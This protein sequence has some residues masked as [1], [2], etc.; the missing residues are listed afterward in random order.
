MKILLTGSSGRVGRAIFGAL[1]ARHEV[2]GVDR[3]PFNTTRY[4]ADITDVRTLRTALVGVDAVIHCAAL[5]APHVG[6][7]SDTEF[8][9]I[10]VEGTRTLAMLARDAGVSRFVFTSTTALYGHA[11]VPG[12][13]TWIDERTVPQ[14]RTVYHRSKLAAEHWL[15]EAASPGFQV[16]VIRMSR[17]FPET[18]QRM[19]LYRLHRGIDVRD[20]A[21]AHAAALRNTGPMFQRYIASGAT[22]FGPED[23]ERLVTE[24]RAVLARRCPQWLAEYDRRGWALPVIDRIHD[25]TAASIGLGWRSQRGPEAV[26]AQLDEHSI[27][28]LPH[29]M[30][31]ADCTVG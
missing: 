28:V 25:A 4:V 10:N 23:C 3:S 5:H 20:V 2:V 16:R 9:R 15:E 24:P 27:E 14:P 8:H 17:C 7:M 26:L 21:D 19:L 30:R 6:L 31:D 18:A 12:R 1:S 13:C 29:P 22:P 11:I